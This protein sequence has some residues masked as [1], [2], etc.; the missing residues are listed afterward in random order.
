MPAYSPKVL[1]DDRLRRIYA[2]LESI[3]EPPDI[4]SLA[5]FFR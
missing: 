2:Y 4:A 1:S 3:P 5:E